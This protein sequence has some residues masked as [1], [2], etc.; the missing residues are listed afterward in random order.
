MKSTEKS[1]S[2]LMEFKPSPSDNEINV[3]AFVSPSPQESYTY[4]K[5]F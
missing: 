5:S 2:N 3:A 4:Y 1:Q